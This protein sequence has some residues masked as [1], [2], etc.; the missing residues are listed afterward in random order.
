MYVCS[1]IIGQYCFAISVMIPCLLREVIVTLFI[2][3]MVLLLSTEHSFLI[4][5]HLRLILVVNMFRL[6]SQH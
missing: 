5:L 6:M 3:K 1:S 4:A 2:L